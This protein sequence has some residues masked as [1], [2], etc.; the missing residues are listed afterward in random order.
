M[1]QSSS[2]VG[3]LSAWVRLGSVMVVALVA[4]SLCASRARAEKTYERQ[5]TERLLEASGLTE[6]ALPAE[7]RIAWVRIV[8]DD[9][10]VRE[11]LQSR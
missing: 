2:W 4:L 6:A 8:R 9:V 1:Q 3:R 5:R 10:F 7:K 11:D